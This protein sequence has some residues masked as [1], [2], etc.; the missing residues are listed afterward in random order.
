MER[1]GS[2]KESVV[3]PVPIPALLTNRSM[4]NHSEQHPLAAQRT[5]RDE[6]Q[7]DIN[8]EIIRRKEMEE[9]GLETQSA[10]SG[11]QGNYHGKFRLDDQS[12]DNQN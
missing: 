11:S 3:A 1:V 7:H 5:I 2:L 9:K 4:R 12:D 8:N 6:I 10:V